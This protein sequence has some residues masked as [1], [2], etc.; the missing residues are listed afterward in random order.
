MEALQDIDDFGLFDEDDILEGDE[1]PDLGMDLGLC[2]LDA[3]LRQDDGKL[4]E[5]VDEGMLV[6][7]GAV[8]VALDEAPTPADNATKDWLALANVAALATFVSAGGEVGGV[9][10]DAPFDDA[11]AAPPLPPPPAPQPEGIAVDGAPL[12]WTKT[13]KGYV[14]T[15]RCAKLGD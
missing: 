5:V 1:S 3:G 15:P 4:Q 8:E 2:A 7:T 13:E 11:A 12:G 9:A 14:F 10:E 6:E